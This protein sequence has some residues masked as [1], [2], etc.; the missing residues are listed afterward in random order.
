MERGL[1]SVVIT[2]YQRPINYVSEALNS[3]LNQTYN[4]IEVI[5][6]DDNGANSKYAIK[7]DKLIEMDSRVRI[8][9]NPQ[10]IGAQK[11]RNLGVQESRGEFI[12]FLDD[13]DIWE[14]RKIEK[15]LE[16]FVSDDIGMAYC[17]GYS[18]VDGD[19][20]KLGVF[21]EASYYKKPISHRL[22]L[23][24]DFIG[25]TSQALIRK[26]VFLN[27]G[28]FDEQMPARQDYE[29]WL[30]ISSKYKIVGTEEK[31]LYYRIHPGDRISTNAEKCYRSYRL[32]LE[33]YQKD[34][35]SNSYAKAKILLRMFEMAKRKKNIREAVDALFDAIAIS[36]QCVIDVVVRRIRKESFMDFYGKKIDTLY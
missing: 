19:M 25:S 23:F 13:D 20:T 27:V 29:M 7:L 28:L 9:H 24:N 35:N 21:R 26:D 8:I 36:P 32:I 11:S 10:N 31:L 6:V 12:A 3:V 34:Y 22:E 33:K 5:I 1:V 18:F 30:R 4:K 16:L 17:D 14:N 2:T 15:Q